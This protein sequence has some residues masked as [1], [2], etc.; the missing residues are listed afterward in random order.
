MDA[1]V[2]PPTYHPD[3]SAGRREAV[4]GHVSRVIDKNRHEERSPRN[5]NT[6]NLQAAKA[7]VNDLRQPFLFTIV[8]ADPA[9]PV[10]V[11]AANPSGPKPLAFR[12]SVRTLPPQCCKLT[13]RQCGRTHM[14]GRVH[15]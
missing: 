10:H 14:T 7:L 11:A 1:A 9:A 13:S 4:D 15:A 3:V 6:T 12:D 8:T 5:V 2:L